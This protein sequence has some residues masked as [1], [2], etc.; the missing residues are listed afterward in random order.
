MPTDKTR[1]SSLQVARRRLGFYSCVHA[2][3]WG[4]V[5]IVSRTD[6]DVDD[7][8]NDVALLASR[9]IED[10]RWSI[11]NF[12]TNQA[13]HRRIPSPSS[14]CSRRLVISRNLLFSESVCFSPLISH[15]ILSG[16]K[17]DAMWCNEI[18]WDPMRSDAIQCYPMLS[19]EMRCDTMWY[20][21]IRYVCWLDCRNG[22]AKSKNG[23]QCCLWPQ[24]YPSDSMESK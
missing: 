9:L 24:F 8:A 11:N 10:Q 17:W 3:D 18:Q 4:L 1:C 21:I 13:N 6:S 12:A 23:Y 2:Y 19:N 14:C 5:T 15:D 16:L 22:Y 7:K 20:E